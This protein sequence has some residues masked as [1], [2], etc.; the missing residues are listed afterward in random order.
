MPGPRSLVTVLNG[1]GPK[2]ANMLK[3][4]GVKNLDD[5]VNKEVPL[6][7]MCKQWY[8]DAQEEAR[9][10]LG[11]KGPS[12]D[13]DPVDDSVNLDKISD[14]KDT[15][16]PKDPEETKEPSKEVFLDDHS[17]FG[18]K[19]QYPRFHKETGE[20]KYIVYVVKCLYVSEN[21]EIR[22]FLQRE[23]N[24]GKFETSLHPLAWV[25]YNYHVLEDFHLTCSTKILKDLPNIE[26]VHNM[27]RQVNTT[28]KI[29]KHMIT[30]GPPESK[31]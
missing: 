13:D 25:V 8:L 17:W 28:M 11:V 27:I 26:S 6:R 14:L 4:A 29:M 30:N 10:Y 15:K 7:I 18:K 5:M 21:S 16:P 22:F 31:I 20:L 3:A 23:T 9:D 19:V 2:K 1:I 12:W 24:E